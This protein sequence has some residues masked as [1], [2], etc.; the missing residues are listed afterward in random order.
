MRKFVLEHPS[1]AT[2]LRQFHEV[3]MIMLQSPLP[4]EDERKWPKAATAT[5]VLQG[6]LAAEEGQGAEASDAAP[7]ELRPSQLL[8]ALSQV[9]RAAAHLGRVGDTDFYLMG[10]TCMDVVDKSY[11]D[12]C[13]VRLLHVPPELRGHGLGRIMMDGLVPEGDTG[14][15][16]SPYALPIAVVNTVEHWG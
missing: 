15:K 5:T 8:A 7:P 4:A 2:L 14:Y 1:A 10:Y 6:P 3:Y 12:P 11:Y 16:F 13:W 9:E